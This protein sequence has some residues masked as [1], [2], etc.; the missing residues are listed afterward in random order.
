[1]HAAETLVILT[2]LLD[3]DIAVGKALLTLQGHHQLAVPSDVMTTLESYH[4]LRTKLVLTLARIQGDVCY[5][6]AVC[7]EMSSPG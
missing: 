1:M 6:K 4:E 2:S 7:D 3:I 5:A